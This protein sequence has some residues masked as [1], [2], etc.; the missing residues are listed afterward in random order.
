MS[1]PLSIAMTIYRLFP[2]G[3]LEDNCLRIAQELL[4]RGHRP[5]IFTAEPAVITGIETRQLHEAMMQKTN[6]RRMERLA[7]LSGEAIA[8]G[9]FD[10]S[11]AFQMMPGTDYVFLADP[12][13]RAS[14][15]DSWKWLT[16]RH[17]V[18]KSLEA[19]T[20][21]TNSKSKVIGL[22][23]GQMQPFVQRY[24]LAAERVRIAP[25]TLN[26]EKIRPQSRNQVTRDKVRA[27]LGIAPHAPVLLA[28]ALHG[29]VK[30]L[31][32]TIAA[33]VRLKD[34]VL[35][36]AGIEEAGNSAADMVMK[37]KNL[38]LE[39]RVRFLGYLAPDAL[40]EAMAAADVLAHPARRDVT[41]AVILESIVNGLPVVATDVCGFSVHIEKSKAGEVLHGP[42]TAHSYANALNRV[43]ASSQVM[44]E[45]GKAYGR[46]PYL[47]SGIFEVCDWIENGF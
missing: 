37:V 14:G 2:K 30:G 13:R 17:H 19:R 3:G 39:K 16:S 35:L 25:P 42:F 21:A 24:N 47:S 23:E 12:I 26:P 44:S 11:I 45:N 8:A 5:V 4:S 31:D 22:S 29:K 28:V 33:L 34:A 20:L 18:Y 36:V 41:G 46:D 43:I 40:I 9:Q 7:L 15:R 1:E 32:R 38:G 10:R 6:H 27:T